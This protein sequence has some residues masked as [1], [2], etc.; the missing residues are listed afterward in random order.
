MAEA[1]GAN[2]HNRETARNI[3]ET[4][5][6]SYDFFEEVYKYDPLQRIPTSAIIDRLKY[7]NIVTEI[8]NGDKRLFM[9]CLLR[10]CL[11][12]E[13]AK[14][15]RADPTSLLFT[16]RP[17][18]ICLFHVL[19]SKLLQ[20]KKF[21]LDDIRHRNKISFR[22]SNIHV[23]LLSKVAFLEVRVNTHE[24]FITVICIKN[25]CCI[26]YIELNYC[27]NKCYDDQY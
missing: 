19:T 22:Y 1:F 18:P 26:F 7:H 13:S 15:S 2:P 20:S 21:K 25:N 10:P 17:Q 16:F 9:S 4:G 6:I 8:G 23:E 3:R 12:E 14:A 24:F 5:E 27:F 11:P